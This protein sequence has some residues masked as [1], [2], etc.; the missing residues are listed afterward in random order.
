MG[1]CNSP[2]TFQRAMQLVLRGLTWEEVVVY[3]DDLIILG[4]SVDNILSILRKVFTRFS[5]NSLKFKP[6]KCTFFQKEVE[7]LGKLVSEKGV[8]IAPGKMDVLK[9]WPRPSN[10]KELQSFLGFMNYHRNH[11]RN[12][13]SVAECLYKRA[14]EKSF[15]WFDEHESAFRQLKEEAIRSPLLSH[16]TPD[17]TFI[18]DVDASNKHIGGALYQKQNDE[19]VPISF[20]SYTLLPA[21]RKYCTTRKEL[22]S[23]VRFCRTYRHYLLGRPFLVRTDHNSLVWL[24]RFKHIEGQLARWLEELS[25]YNMTIEHRKGCEHTN[26][27]A[28]SRM[29]DPLRFCD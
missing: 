6:R 5:Q 7:F 17:G 12:F 1:L 24:T 26:A 11:I 25:Q 3:L 29:G 16:P 23:L 14:I 8:S 21:Q 22:L 4:T 27:D 2:A 9:S 20:G 15:N 18:L 28:L 13:A 10:A 19:L